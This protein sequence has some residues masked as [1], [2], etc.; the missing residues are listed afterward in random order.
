MPTKATLFGLEI[1]F[2]H[3]EQKIAEERAQRAKTKAGR[4][5]QKLD[6]VETKPRAASNMHGEVKTKKET[7]QQSALSQTGLQATAG[8]LFT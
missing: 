8:G 6:K 4:S 2:R 7:A 1:R 5:K 3:I